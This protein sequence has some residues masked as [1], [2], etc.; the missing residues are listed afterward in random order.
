MI[1]EPDEQ[2]PTV[3]KSYPEE[4][5]EYCRGARLY[6]GAVLLFIPIML[7]S[8]WISV[9]AGSNISSFVA[10]IILLMAAST[11]GYRLNQWICPRCGNKFQEG[12]RI[13]IPASRC[14]TCGLPLR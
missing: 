12:R 8:L 2:G 13:K 7:I 4:F 11:G 9:A 6:W 5:E 1:D 3:E 10:F 14:M